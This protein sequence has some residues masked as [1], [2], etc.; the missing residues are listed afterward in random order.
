MNKRESML[1]LGCCAMLF[2]GTPL[3]VPHLATA[4]AQTVRPAE[5]GWKNTP[6]T[7]RVSNETLGNVL[8]K[9]AKS[10]GADLVFQGVTLV[11]INELTTLNV[12]DKPLDKVIG[13]LIGDQNVRIDYQGGH[14]AI[15]ISPYER[16]VDTAQSFEVGGVVLGAD[17]GKPLVGATVSV[18]NG[19]NRKGNMGCIT[20]EDGKFSLRVNRKASISISYL[21]YDTK[22]IQILRPNLDMKI[23]LAPNATSTDEVVVTGISRRNKKSFTGNYVS[24]KGEDLR[25]INPNNFLQSLQFYDPSFKVKENNSK[26]SDPN[27]QPEFQMRGDQ[28]LGS[29]TSMNSM[30]L[31]LDNVSSRPNTPLFVLDGFVVP[32][33]RILS[34]DP[35]RIDEVT[36]LKDAAATAIYGSKAS[37]GVVVISTKVAPDGDDHSVA[38]LDRL[39]HDECLGE[40]ANRMDGR[41]IRSK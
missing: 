25:R 22:S 28:S 38:R 34:L 19:T 16:K 7:L 13:E 12:K 35:E 9:V 29:T 14:H 24:V 1:K 26:G 2:C 30:D 33:T 3:P 20:D 5:D 32:M 21:G 18:T 40:T 37:N 10:V 31:L 17:D 41:S 11:G 36:I 8:A 15:V 23:S 27:A 39:Q 4:L 6:V